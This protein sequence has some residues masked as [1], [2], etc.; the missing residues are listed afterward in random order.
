MNTLWSRFCMWFWNGQAYRGLHK[1]RRQSGLQILCRWIFCYIMP[2][3]LAICGL[4]ALYWD[5]HRQPV[6]LFVGVFLIGWAYVQYRIL[7]TFLGH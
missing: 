2:I 3:I 5:L 1:P 6:G 7:I 4:E